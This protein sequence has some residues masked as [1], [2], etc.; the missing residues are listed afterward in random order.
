MVQRNG[1]KINMDE[2]NKSRNKWQCDSLTWSCHGRYA[3]CGLSGKVE[4][5]D[6]SQDAGIIKIWDSFTNKTIHDIAKDNGVKLTNY[7]FVLAG[8]PKNEDIFFSGS[9]GGIIC[10]WNIK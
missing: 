7:S 10:L 5:N 4:V 3:I 8:H 2:I 9:D 6:T 1:N